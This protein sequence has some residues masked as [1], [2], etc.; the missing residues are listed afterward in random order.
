MTPMIRFPASIS[1]ALL[2]AVSM[3]LLLTLA[4]CATQE[5]EKSGGSTARQEAAPDP[6]SL[7]IRLGSDLIRSIRDSDYGSFSRTLAGK[8]GFDISREEFD[9]S[10]A[11]VAEKYGQ[12]VFWSH[13]TAL[14]DP[15][16]GQ[17]IWKVHFVKNRKEGKPVERDMLFRLACAKIGENTSVLAFGF[18]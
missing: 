15:V 1:R 9:S 18:F 12:P 8:T 6:A 14:E 10:C 7:E 17:H 11:G 5:A 2:P 13:L 4:S 16:A 3:V